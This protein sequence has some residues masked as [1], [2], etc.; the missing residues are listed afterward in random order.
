MTRFA[1]RFEGSRVTVHGFC[2]PPP[3]AARES[4]LRK[5]QTKPYRSPGRRRPRRQGLAEL[6]GGR[7]T[8]IW[9]QLLDET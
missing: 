7:A 4:C 2:L 9:A 5:P 8:D 6:S 1:T 3:A